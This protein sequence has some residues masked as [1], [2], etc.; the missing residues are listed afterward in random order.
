MRGSFYASST[1]ASYRPGVLLALTLVLHS[2]SAWSQTQLATVFGTV[3]DP[4]GA[5]IAGAD[6]TVSSTSTGL[7]REGLTDLKGEYR[8]AGLP[9]GTYAVRAAKEKFQTQVLEGIAL[10][11]GASIA[12]NLSMKVGSV[13][14]DVTVKADAAIDTTT[15]TIS[16]AIAEPRL[17]E[18]PLNGRDLFKSTILEPG[19]APT[20]SSAPSLLS[21]G[22]ANQVSVDGMR[23]TWTNVLVDGMDANDPVFGLSPAGASGLFLGLDG[24]TEVRILSQTFDAEY[25][26]NGGGVIE[27]VTKSGS[28]QFHGSLW[29][30]HRD[31]SLDARNYFDLGSRPIPAFVRNQFGASIG[32]PLVHDRTFFFANYEGFREV[33]AST[34]I[35]TVPNALAHQGLLPSTS[36][37]A[38]CSSATPNACVAVA[39]D[40]RVQQFLDLVPPSN[41][42]GNGDGTGDLITANK[43]DINEHHG[44]V[45]VDHNFS[46]THSILG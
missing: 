41:G 16:E 15:S 26:T 18:L 24:L 6:V 12:I 25:G 11:S 2:V 8:V 28:N 30:S 31:A 4:T 39:I 21:D 32:G 35:A 7:K 9:Q 40:A 45:R 42:A 13:P 10:S 33:Q 3:S 27:T 34:A 38:G 44:M 46:N 20:P 36:N 17:T 5:V 1:F 22:K 14:Q 43:G 29:E 23:P 37:P 19:V